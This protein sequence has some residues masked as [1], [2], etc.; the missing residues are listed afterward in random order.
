[1][2]NPGGLWSA[3]RLERGPG[4]AATK[5][6]KERNHFRIPE[7]LA[8]P[9]ILHKSASIADHLGALLFDVTTREKPHPLIADVQVW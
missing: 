6:T 5:H 4:D 7:S 8:I 3:P 2:A 9:T 1:M